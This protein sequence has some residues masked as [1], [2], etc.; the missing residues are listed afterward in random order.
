VAIERKRDRGLVFAVYCPHHGSRV[1]LCAD[2]IE[3]IVN[4]PRG[5][6]V[7]WRC[8]CGWAGVLRTGAELMAIPPEEGVQCIPSS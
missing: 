1:L 5:I 4:G 6:D 8:P 7:H 2:D 3:T